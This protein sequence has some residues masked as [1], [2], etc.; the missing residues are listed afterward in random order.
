MEDPKAGAANFHLQ[1]VAEGFT[2][3]HESNE[4]KIEYTP[5]FLFLA[6]VQLLTKCFFCSIVLVH[7]LGGH[8]YKTWACP[9]KNSKSSAFQQ[10]ATSGPKPPS[11]RR[12][13]FRHL[14]RR[15][16][17]ARGRKENEEREEDEEAHVY[18]PRDFL[19]YEEECKQARI[20]T[21]GYDSKITRG[22]ENANLNTFFSHAKD[23][24][25]GLRREKPPRRAV[26]FVAHS[27]G[28]L[29]VKEVGA[30]VLESSMA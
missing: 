3:L 18:W 2:V 28:G 7:G 20:L 26:I 5:A 1:Q 21:Y 11:K 30:Q 25:Y 27:L 16:Y 9:R 17:S 24:L 15:F 4:A 6:K 19:A 14:F 13:K 23:F 8:P 22:Y 12:R 10:T 29:L